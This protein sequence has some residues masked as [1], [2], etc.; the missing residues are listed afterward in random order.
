MKKRI[1]FILLSIFILLFLYIIFLFENYVAENQLIY[2]RKYLENETLTIDEKIESANLYLESAILTGEINEVINAYSILGNIFLSNFNYQKSLAYFLKAYEYLDDIKSEKIKSDICY[3]IGCNYLELGEYVKAYEF[4]MISYLIEKKEKESKRYAETLNLLGNIY[5]KTGLYTKSLA[6]HYESLELQKSLNNIKGIANSNHNIAHINIMIERYNKAFNYYSKALE[7]YEKLYANSPDSIELSTNL[8]KIYLSIGNYYITQKDSIYALSY[9]DL[10]MKMSKKIEDKS[11]TA[12]CLSYIANVYFQCNDFI[13]A[14]NYYQESLKIN[15]EENNKI[16]IVVNNINLG[17]IYYLTNKK[18]EA[19]E[20]LKNSLNIASEINA[21]RQMA[22]VSEFLYLIYSEYPDSIEQSNNYATIFLESKKYLLNEN[23]QDSII[24]LSVKCE[25]TAEKNK[26]ISLQKYKMKTNSILFIFILVIV[27]GSAIFIYY[28]NKLR[29]KAKY[30]RKLSD[31]QRI[32]IKEVF[33]AIEQE[34]KRIAIDLHDSLGQMLTA[35]KLNLSI[36]EDLMENQ[37]Q[38]DQK[39]YYD[40]IKMLDQSSVEL[41]NISFNILPGTLIR[42]GLKSAIEEVIYKI[43][44][45]N[46]IEFDFKSSGFDK[47]NNGTFEI[48]IYRIV[49]EILNNIMKHAKATLVKIYLSKK[50]E[51]TTLLIEDNGI[52]MENIEMYMDKGLG[53][54]S[55]FSRVQMLNGDIKINTGINKG[56]KIDILISEEV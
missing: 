29:Q 10:A 45:K 16:G 2:H 23:I 21:K 36:L 28:Y 33:N 9:L 8:V 34:R 3:K 11:S 26:E 20:S 25:V 22:E 46:R 30:E 43:N 39:L 56:T 41:R 48:I 42:G 37:N 12:Q 14:Q 55:I 31:E 19:I 24:Q 13:K 44:G 40:T 49:Q 27:I 5:E 1:L 47:S 6:T 7:I 38:S 53:W 18:R 35:T 52:G 17:R 50:T 51:C 32:R 4:A 54:K 15:E